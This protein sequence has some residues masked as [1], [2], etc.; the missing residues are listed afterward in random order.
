MDLIEAMQ[1]AL[2]AAKE[3]LKLNADVPVGCAIYR[4]NALIAK[5]F[6]TR[7]RDRSTTGHAEITAITEACRILGDWR[8]TDCSIFVTLEPCPMCAGAIAAA[9]FEK[10]VFGAPRTDGATPCHMI[11]PEDIKI[12]P[13]ICCR[14]A[15]ELL[16]AFFAGRRLSQTEVRNVP[17]PAVFNKIE[18]KG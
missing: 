4:G 14:E 1:P 9:R 13:G 2:E 6:N 16:K 7:Q 17:G 12:Y 11:L 5:A 8:L 3:C 15:S 18:R 10:L